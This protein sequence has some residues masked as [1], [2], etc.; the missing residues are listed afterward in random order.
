MYL[1]TQTDTA[2]TRFGY[3]HGIEIIAKAG[4]DA[5]DLSM[6]NMEYDDSPFI[7][8]DCEDF[9]LKLKKIAEDNG[10]FFNQAH[11][12][13]P[14]IDPYN[15]E[16]TEKIFPRTCKSIELAGIVGARQ[17]IVHP[18]DFMRNV[19]YPNAEK[20]KV[21][22]EKNIEMYNKLA[23]Y[24]KPYGI[25]IALENMWDWNPNRE[26]ITSNVCSDPVE[27]ADFLDAL[28]SDI[29]CACLD[30]GHC[31]L[32]GVD[33]KDAIETL[34]HDKLQ[35][36]HVHDTDYIHDMHT[37]PYTAKLDWKKIT[38]ALKDIDYSGDLTFEADYFFANMP[39]E[40]LESAYKFLHDIGRILIS[41]IKG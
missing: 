3:E 9:V 31:G 6:F 41:E 40:L 35:A 10:V 18:V 17:I 11:A 29:F 27:F 15:D 4:F 7:T 19:F 12:P 32:V 24:A 22:K 30:I 1:S 25:K 23:E 13:F 34:G 5:L 39:N 20:K 8:P 26:V 37:A 2:C 38:K 33:E 14:P 21:N 16:Y 28:D 36:L